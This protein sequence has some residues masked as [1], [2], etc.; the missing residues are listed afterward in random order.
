MLVE[1]P[2]NCYLSNKEILNGGGPYYTTPLIQFYIQ[3]PPC[4]YPARRPTP[5]E[6]INNIMQQLG[7]SVAYFSD[8]LHNVWVLNLP[9]MDQLLKNPLQIRRIARNLIT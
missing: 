7:L 4:R 5:V 2:S 8:G 9:S 1:W 3:Y 6:H